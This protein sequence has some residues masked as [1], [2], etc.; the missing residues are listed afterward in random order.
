[1]V[2]HEFR[3]ACRCSRIVFQDIEIAK[4]IYDSITKHDEDL[5]IK[6]FIQ[7]IRL[8]KFG[9]LTYCEKQVFLICLVC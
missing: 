7:E 5:S 3:N 4:N 6:G 1:M 8:Y 9:F 2:K